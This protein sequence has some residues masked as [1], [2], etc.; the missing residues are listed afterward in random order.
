M[1]PRLYMEERKVINQMRYACESRATIAKRR[2]HH[3]STIGRE[4]TRIGRG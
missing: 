1:A 4:L 3:K 2:S